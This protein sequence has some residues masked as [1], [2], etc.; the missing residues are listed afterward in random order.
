[1]H[2]RFHFVGI[3]VVCLLLAAAVAQRL[4]HP[5]APDT[6][7]ASEPLVA[8]EASAPP[9]QDQF[10]AQIRDE[11]V[12]VDQTVARIKDLATVKRDHERRDAAAVRTPEFRGLLR[13][14]HEGS[15]SNVLQSHW[16][17]YK[18]LLDTAKLAPSGSTPCTICDGQGFM[19]QC[20]LCP[21]HDGKCSSCFG[22]GRLENDEACPTCLGSRKCF[23]CFGT[24]RMPCPFCVD[25]MVEGGNPPPPQHLPID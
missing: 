18:T 13:I 11:F 2:Q 12:Q 1:M 24:G 8:R 5:P 3:G 16:P 22:S 14:A 20:V 6:A 17:I 15:W 7:E 19:K 9:G 23:L 4:P 25:G 10:A 21:N